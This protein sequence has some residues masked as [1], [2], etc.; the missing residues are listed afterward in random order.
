MVNWK[1]VEIWQNISNERFVI[2]AQNCKMED[3]TSGHYQKILILQDYGQF[4]EI[5]IVAKLLPYLPHEMYWVSSSLQVSQCLYSKE[6]FISGSFFYNHINH[7]FFIL[8]ASITKEISK[9]AIMRN[10]STVFSYLCIYIK[11]SISF[12]ALVIFIIVL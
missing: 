6:H 7:F 5:Q 9:N 10:K 2:C 12:V 11:T 4:N 1:L 3:A 8:D